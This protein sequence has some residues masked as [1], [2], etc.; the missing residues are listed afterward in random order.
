MPIIIIAIDTV[1][2]FLNTLM[3][4]AMLSK[5]A[6]I[7]LAKKISVILISYCQQHTPKPYKNST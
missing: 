2:F 5:V 1:V 3:I 4:K 7:I 6:P